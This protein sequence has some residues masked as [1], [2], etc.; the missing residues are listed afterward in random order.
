MRTKAILLLL[1]CILLADTSFARKRKK[2]NR[3]GYPY[4]RSTT[5]CVKGD[6]VNGPG[7]YVFPDDDIFDGYW[8]NGKRHGQGVYYLVDKQKWSQADRRI[9]RW[10]DG[11]KHGRFTYVYSNG[12][13]EYE[14]WYLNQD[15]RDR[16]H[17]CRNAE[18]LTNAYKGFVAILNGAVAASRGD[19]VLE[20]A[21]EG[22]GAADRQLV[23]RA[24]GLTCSQFL[25]TFE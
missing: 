18:T 6:C 22:Y 1:I 15:V 21:A 10:I 11:K 13:R 9:G 4:D 5:G 24:V 25:K 14:Y 23:P 19:D 8:R 20:S 7:V 16:V 17:K 3:D 2:K 12:G